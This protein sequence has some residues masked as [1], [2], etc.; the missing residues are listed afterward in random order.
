MFSGLVHI[1]PMSFD[2]VLTL[3]S[4]SNDIAR[5]ARPEHDIEAEASPCLIRANLVLIRKE[6]YR[7]HDLPLFKR[8]SW[9]IPKVSVQEPNETIWSRQ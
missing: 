3:S 4:R 2:L 7:L 9:H 1:E 8:A 6:S 5:P